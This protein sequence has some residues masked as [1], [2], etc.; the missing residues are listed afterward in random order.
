[1]STYELNKQMPQD[2]GEGHYYVAE[3]ADVIGRVR[4]RL[5]ASIWFGAVIRGDNEWIDI[6]ERTNIHDNCTLHTDPSLPLTIDR[7]CTVGHN[8]ILHSCLIG[9]NSLIRMGAILL[10]G[11][12]IGNNSI[13]GASTL[14][15]EG[16]EFPDNSVIAGIPARRVRQIDADEINT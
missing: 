11:A 5:N 10:S 9:D 1:M 4:I 12:K 6:G 14:V 2:P 8:A 15:P 7:N 13:V 3:T 16:R